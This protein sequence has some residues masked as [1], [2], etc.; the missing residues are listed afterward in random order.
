[1]QGAY[2]PMR[3]IPSAI[4]HASFLPLLHREHTWRSIDGPSILAENEAPKTQ[5]KKRR[6]HVETGVFRLFS[7]ERETRLELATFCMASRC[8]TN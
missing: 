1:M 4:G 3:P 8:S 2:R 6:F 7:M 5:N